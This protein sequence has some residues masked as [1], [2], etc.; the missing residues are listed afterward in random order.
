MPMNKPLWKKILS[1]LDTIEIHTISLETLPQRVIQE[2]D[3]CHIDYKQAEIPT[4]ISNLD[5]CRFFKHIPCGIDLAPAATILAKADSGSLLEGLA[6]FECCYRM[7]QAQVQWHDLFHQMTFPKSVFNAFDPF[8]IALCKQTCLFQKHHN[9]LSLHEDLY[10]DIQAVITEYE[11]RPD[12]LLSTVLC[13]RYCASIIHH[14]SSLIYKNQEKTINDYPEKAW[15]YHVLPQHGVP[16]DRSETKSLQAFFKDT[17]FHEFDHSCALCGI[18]IAA[19]LVASHIKPFR[20]CAH[21]YETIDHNNGLLLCRNH[22]FLFDQGYITFT[23]DGTIRISRSCL[24]QSCFDAFRLRHDFHIDKK[25]LTPQRQCF[26]AYHHRYI[27]QDSL[28]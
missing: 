5:R 13:A 27:F 25:K 7:D 2:L 18:D 15:I 10:R 12:Q 1:I 11:N 20:D 17:L 9:R 14:D 28:S 8:C 19:M 26:F 23:A 21:I 6:M 22:D 24:N 3:T 4:L 16:C